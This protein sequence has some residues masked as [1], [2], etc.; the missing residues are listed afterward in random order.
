[1]SNF[2]RTPHNGQRESI[3][4]C[5]FCRV[6]II[7][8]SPKH[9]E[10]DMPCPNSLCKHLS[11]TIPQHE[12]Y[13]Y[14]RGWYNFK[15]YN[16]VIMSAMTS[17]ITSLTSVYSTVYI[18]RRSKKTSK[19]RATGLCVGNSQGTNGKDTLALVFHEKCICCWMV[20]N[21]NSF[22]YAVNGIIHWS[23]LNAITAD[24]KAL[25]A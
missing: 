17:Q 25:R 15:H 2:C 3:S 22:W 10:E 18:R 1:M 21:E 13:S 20:K 8:Y 23:L 16:D 14:C 5:K 11:T 6:I 12:R 19:L 24:T 9:P 7:Y 4:L